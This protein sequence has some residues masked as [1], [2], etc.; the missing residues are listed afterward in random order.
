ML[1]IIRTMLNKDWLSQHTECMLR[2]PIIVQ[3]SE[4]DLLNIY[5]MLNKILVLYK[6]TQCVLK[7]CC[8]LQQGILH[9]W[10]MF[11]AGS[12]QDYSLNKKTMPL[13]I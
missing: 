7:V 3:H 4:S 1:S 5:N 11:L 6:D 8:L 12:P 2:Q 10:N 13:N 9:F